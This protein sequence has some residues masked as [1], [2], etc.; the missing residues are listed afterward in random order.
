MQT[1][2]AYRGGANM[3]K[4]EIYAMMNSNIV[5]FL[6]TLDADAPRVRGMMLYRADRDGIV[7][8][9]G[10][11]KDIYRQVRANPAAEL[12]FWDARQNLQVRVSGQLEIVDDTALKE[13]I[14]AHPSR[15]FVKEWKDS[16]GTEEF[17]KTFVVMRMTGGKAKTWTMASNFDSATPIA[18]D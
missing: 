7:F 15:G 5:F 2:K 12:C 13:E 8:H 17:Y 4:D 9:T 18:L 11:M 10:T 3:N 16:V 6:A 14:A 1:I